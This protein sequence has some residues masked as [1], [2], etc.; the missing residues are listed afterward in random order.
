MA[1]LLIDADHYLDYLYRNG[2]RDFS[3]KR[4]VRFHEAIEPIAKG[5]PFLGLN[6]FHTAEAMAAVCLLGALT[7]HL[8]FLG[9]LGGMLFHMALDVVHLY[10]TGLLFKRA[11]SIV[12]YLVRWN[13]MERRGLKPEAPYR[14]ALAAIRGANVRDCQGG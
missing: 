6:V 8:F 13:L 4:A 10:R 3:L 11:Y 2:L 14:L 7:G 5:R 9:V 1:S 12:E